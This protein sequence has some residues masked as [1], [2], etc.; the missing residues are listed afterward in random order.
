MII[1]PL[2]TSHNKVLYGYMHKISGF[3]QNVSH[4]IKFFFKNNKTS[5]SFVLVFVVGLFLYMFL[6]SSS[7]EN[8]SII[9]NRGEVIQSVKVSGAVKA[10]SEANMSFEKSAPLSYIGVKVGDKV[11]RGKVLATVSSGDEEANLLQA[12]ASLDNAKA[13]LDQLT[14]GARQ[15]EVAI[16]EQAKKGSENNLSSVYSSLPDSIHN[17]E[18]V[19]SDIIKSK[20]S[21]M[22]IYT[23]NRY[24]LS[25]SSC[26]QS[27]QSQ[28]ESKR[29][30]IEEDL[31][32][33]QR[34][35]SV[36]SALSQTEEIDK[37]FGEAYTITIKTNELVSLISTLLLLPCS[38]SNTSLDSYR[39]TLS[40]VK[41]STNAIFADITLK[42]TNLITAKNN[43]SLASSEF[44][45]IKAGTDPSL[46][47]AQEALVSSARAKLLNAQVQLQKTR[48][49]AP[50]DGVVTSVSLVA[51]EVA[52]IGSPVIK[53]ISGNS[54]EVEA[55]VREIDVA[56][57]KVND[58]VKITLDTYG[59]DVVFPGFVSRV[60]PS[61][62]DGD[63]PMYKILVSFKEQDGRIRDKMTANVS[64]ITSAKDNAI[65]LPIRFVKT[66]G[67]KGE[68]IIKGK[69]GKEEVREVEVG[70]LGEDG[71]V[72][73]VSGLMS[74][75]EVLAIKP[76]ERSAQKQ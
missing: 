71:N 69:D 20:L 30:A 14:R 57:I 41:T 55:K 31:G 13:T 18:Q 6:S 60:N 26:D 11:Y 61:G 17:T 24:T 67:S 39:T 34:S 8:E 59:S 10:V 52:T 4:F 36:I 27:I 7:S 9:V 56:K 47:L 58:Q 2:N 38:S 44:D 48:I 40:A 50:F 66:K 12:Q 72:E 22:F 53:L 35:S 43:Y 45:L 64:I 65:I 74:G 51:G 76:G 21:S 19:T 29:I 63:I 3:L 28:L 73:I 75:D 42:R 5:V 32:R 15:E 49:V 46:I 62:E 37:V 70:I 33:F 68:V 1:F 25:F 23:G 16:K 54:F